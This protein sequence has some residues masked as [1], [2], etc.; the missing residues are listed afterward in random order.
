[1]GDV[2]MI[3]LRNDILISDL[4]IHEY[5]PARYLEIIAK[6]PATMVFARFRMIQRFSPFRYLAASSLSLGLLATGCAGDIGESDG[7]SDDTPGTTTG[8]PGH[9]D[10]PTVGA[11]DACSGAT[12][13]PA[14]VRKITDDQYA[15]LVTDLL[16][17]VMPDKVATPGPSLALIKDADEFVVRGPLAAQY[18]DGALS[19]AKQAV[20]N[21]AQLVPCSAAPTDTAAQ[22]TCAQKSSNRSDR[23][24]S[25]GRCNPMTP[26]RSSKFTTRAR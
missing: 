14:R 1:M 10:D 19:V 18:W 20:T 6:G 22:R 4:S 25:A 17:G 2:V 26:C 9:V 23:R 13:V 5:R 12:L 8:G 24:L 21:L 3:R 7:M 16:P 11:V 15:R